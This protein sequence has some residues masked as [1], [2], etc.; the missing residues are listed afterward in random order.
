MIQTF[1]FILEAQRNTMTMNE[2]R[3]CLSSKTDREIIIGE[4]RLTFD[5]V[6]RQV[7]IEDVKGYTHDQ[8]RI[9]PCK[10]P[11]H[12]LERALVGEYSDFSGL[13]WM[14]FHSDTG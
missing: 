1:D 2:I 9:V 3:S 4:H 7:T 8:S 14:D 12:L 13:E 10:M 5:A 6:S 11:Y